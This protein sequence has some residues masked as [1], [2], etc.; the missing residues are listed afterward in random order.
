MSDPVTFVIYHRVKRG[1]YSEYEQWLE[2]IMPVARSYPGHLGVNVI[3]PMAGEQ[4]YTVIIRFT[5]TGHMR[6]WVESDDRRRLIGE[7]MPF[8][9]EGDRTEIREGGEFWF[10]PPAPGA[11]HPVRWKQFLITF[12]VILPLTMIVP[13]LW[14]PLF[15]AWPWLAGYIQSKFAI[16]ATIV[17]IVVYLVMPYYTR[18]VA[19]WLYR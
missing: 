16:A 10:T 2:R 11:K 15:R 7:V 9:E 19:K 1:L 3:R 4:L 13:W 18:L 17:F 14:R 5:G 8:L 12:S 6:S